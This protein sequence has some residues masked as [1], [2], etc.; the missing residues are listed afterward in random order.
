MC[1]SLSFCI[2]RPCNPPP[3]P[4]GHQRPPPPP[5]YNH[6][7]PPSPRSP[8]AKSLGRRELMESTQKFSVG[9]GRRRWCEGVHPQ[10][11]KHIHIFL[12]NL[13]LSNPP[14][15]PPFLHPSFTYPRVDGYRL[16]LLLLLFRLLLN[17]FVFCSRQN[18]RGHGIIIFFWG[19]GVLMIMESLKKKDTS[20]L[21]HFVYTYLLTYLLD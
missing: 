12:A 19:G 3:P 9:H 11:E 15:P 6:P 2:K 7:H 10:A 18:V 17:F 1:S 13:Y 4:F 21:F 14:P 20:H 16:T 8:L 5:I